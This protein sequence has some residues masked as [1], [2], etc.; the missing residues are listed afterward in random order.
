MTRGDTE[1]RPADIKTLVEEAGA[2]AL[3]GSREHGIKS[4]FEFGP[5]EVFVMVDKVQIQ[6]VLI[7]LMRNA[8][9]AMRDSDVK[10]LLVSTHTV[11]ERMRVEVADTGPGVSD[12]IA[13]RLFQPFVTT[14][15]GGM[16]VGLSISKRIIESHGGE[17]TAGRNAAGGATFVFSLPIV[18]EEHR[19]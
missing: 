17:M 4:I 18:A 10:E 15:S 13:E 12:E 19:E 2:L 11:G 9:E 8:M 6:Q 14:K 5:E 1:K 7:N 3:V 16:G